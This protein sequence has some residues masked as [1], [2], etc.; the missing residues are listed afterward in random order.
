MSS[1][2]FSTWQATSTPMGRAKSLSTW[3]ICT[4]RLRAKAAPRAVAMPW[5]V[6]SPGG[7]S[8]RL[9]NERYSPPGTS[10]TEATKGSAKRGW[11]A[12]RRGSATTSTAGAPSTTRA[13]R[14]SSTST[15]TARRPPWARCIWTPAANHSGTAATRRAAASP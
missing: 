3:A 4:L 5:V 1:A 13:V 6:R 2:M 8:R 15:D 7:T 14:A 11:S 12:A 9:R 10:T